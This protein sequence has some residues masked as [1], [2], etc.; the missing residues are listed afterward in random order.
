MTRFSERMGFRPAKV[1]QLDGM[2]TDLRIGLWNIASPA[3]FVYRREYGRAQPPGFWPWERELGVRLW[4]DFFKF[5]V[6]TMPASW[7]TVAGQMREWFFN[8]K[9]YEAYDFVEFLAINGVDSGF[10]SEGSVKFQDACNRMLEREASGYRL[11]NGQLQ[12]ITDESELAAVD[13]AFKATAG[14][15]AQRHLRLALDLLSDR[16]TPDYRASAHESVKAVECLCQ[17]LLP[18]E[19]ATLETVLKQMAS[20]AGPHNAL[21]PGLVALF[22]YSD[23]SG[24]AYRLLEHPNIG[25]DEAKFLAVACSAAINYLKVKAPLLQAPPPPPVPAPRVAQPGRLVSV[26]R[27]PTVRRD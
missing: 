2:D 15:E 10:S 20:D 4:R 26:N 5:A 21:R 24:S 17:Q 8:A 14:T 16:E 13:A 19:T 1:L 7:M 23:A 12:A 3:F 6:D 9:W 27:R 18:G 25:F 11:L 22:G